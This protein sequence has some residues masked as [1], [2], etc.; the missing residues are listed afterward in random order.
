VESK[1]SVS[2]SGSLSLLSM[3]FLKLTKKGEGKKRSGGWET[4]KRVSVWKPD[5]DRKERDERGSGV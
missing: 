2:E 5:G 4:H 3:F 1:K